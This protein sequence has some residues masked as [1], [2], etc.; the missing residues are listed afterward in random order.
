MQYEG[1]VFIRYK[2]E[3]WCAAAAQRDPQAADFLLDEHIPLEDRFELAARIL[4]PGP[5]TARTVH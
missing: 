3:S 5:E 1:P 2:Q 4:C